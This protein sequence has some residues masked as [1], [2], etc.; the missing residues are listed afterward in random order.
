MD[1]VRS[2]AQY[3]ENLRFGDAPVAIRVADPPAE[4]TFCAQ[5]EPGE[6]LAG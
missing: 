2:G 1:I 3:R 5:A 4:T 6:R